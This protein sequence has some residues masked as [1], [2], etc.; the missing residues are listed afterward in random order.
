MTRIATYK[1]DLFAVDTIVIAFE[2]RERPGFALEVW[3]EC[4][5][6]RALFATLHSEFDVDPEW[7]GTVML[8]AFAT[9]Y[10]VLF[11]RPASSTSP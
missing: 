7:Y 1:L 6:F 10:R 11:E 2:T 9:N 5:G 8:P 4:L 3:E